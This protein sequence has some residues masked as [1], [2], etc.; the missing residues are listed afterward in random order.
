M[1]GRTETV[2]SAADEIDEGADAVGAPRWTAATGTMTWSF[3]ISRSS[4]MLTNW[5]GNSAPS[6]LSN[7]ARSLIVPVVVSIW[8]SRVWSVAVGELGAVARGRRPRPSAR[9]RRAGACGPLAG[10]LP[11]WGRS[12]RSAAAG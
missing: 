6:L 1:T 10:C 5:L 7:M 8:L 4:W 9:R 2:L 3:R 11:A 12:P